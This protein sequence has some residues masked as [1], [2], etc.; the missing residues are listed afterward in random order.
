MRGRTDSFSQQV[1]TCESLSLPPTHSGHRSLD[2]SSGQSPSAPPW[3][4][5]P[6]AVKWAGGSSCL[7]AVVLGGEGLGD[8]PLG[9]TVMSGGTF[10]LSQLGRGRLVAFSRDVP[11][12]LTPLRTAPQSRMIWSQ[13]PVVLKVRNLTLQRGQGDLAS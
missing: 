13:M 10:E 1:S 9:C 4:S 11:K 2:R 6:S 3:A 8:A 7:R 5:I 12:H